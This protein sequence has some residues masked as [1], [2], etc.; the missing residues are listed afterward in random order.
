MNSLNQVKMMFINHNES[1]EL[2]RHL[3]IIH[4]LSSEYRCIDIM[5][6]LA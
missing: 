5:C 3:A 1:L 2:I 6:K 4:K